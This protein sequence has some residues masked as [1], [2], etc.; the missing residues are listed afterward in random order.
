[1][2]AILSPCG[3]YR[4]RLERDLGQPG[5]VVAFFGI[6]PSTA[7]ALT[8]DATIRKMVGFASRW[9]YSKIL[10]G[11]AFAFRAK[12]VCKLAG[13]SDPIGPEWLMHINAL[14]SDADILIPCWGNKTK[15]PPQLRQ[16]LIVLTRLLLGTGKR[17]AAFGWTASHDPLHPL[18]LGYSTALVGWE[19]FFKLT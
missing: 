9:G 10:V 12:D 6:N 8:D 7:D 13:V 4:Y 16:Q 15:V 19:R 11:N 17:V 2:S 1:M 18:M 5:P 14:M 3:L